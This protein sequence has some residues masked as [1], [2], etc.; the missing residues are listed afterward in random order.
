[1]AS[2]V[3]YFVGSLSAE[4]IN[5][6][7]AENVINFLPHKLFTPTTPPT[8]PVYDDSTITQTPNRAKSLRQG[9][10]YTPL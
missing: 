9:A 2:K 10:D 1:M 7:V 6:K 3:G 5:R 8:E 4:S